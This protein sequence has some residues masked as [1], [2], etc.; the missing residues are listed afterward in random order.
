MAN[1]FTSPSGIVAESA[2]SP[3]LRI[4]KFPKLS[5][6]FKFSATFCESLLLD[7]VP[8]AM[9]TASLPRTWNKDRDAV[10]ALSMQFLP[11]VF[12]MES[13]QI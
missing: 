7:E 6:W 12:W 4:G 11:D 3:K 8:Y 5:F 10:D 2:S 13:G 9:P 1:T